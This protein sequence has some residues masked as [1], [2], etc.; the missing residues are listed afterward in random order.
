M[1]CRITKNTYCL[2]VH[3]TV[4]L[5]YVVDVISKEQDSNLA[6]NTAFA[7]VN[8]IEGGG[9]GGSGGG[10]VSWLLMVLF[11]VQRVCMG[12]VMRP[13]KCCHGRSNALLRRKFLQ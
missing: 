6:N 10:S 9:G 7:E 2:L 1:A 13:G 8:V 11:L 4:L 3:K 5:V 12:R